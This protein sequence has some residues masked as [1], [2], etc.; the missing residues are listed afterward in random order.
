[1]KMTLKDTIAQSLEILANRD[2]QHCMSSNDE[3]VVFHASEMVGSRLPKKYNHI[4]MNRNA[5]PLCWYSNSK[6]SDC[7]I[8]S[9]FKKAYAKVVEY[10]EWGYDI[11]PGRVN[12]LSDILSYRLQEYPKIKNDYADKKALHLYLRNLNNLRK[13]CKEMTESEIYDFSFDMVYDFFD[14][15]SLSE[16]TLSLSF[17]IM[18]W[19]QRE[20]DLIPVAVVGD[21]DEFLAALNPHSEYMP[22]E[23]ESKKKF[24]H[25]MRKTLHTHLKLFIRNEPTEKPTS[26]DRILKLIK[27]NPKH[28]AKEMASCLGL[29][30]Q[31]VQKQIAI[32]KKEKRLKRT[33]ADHGGKWEVIEKK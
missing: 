19:I 7:G 23:R 14:N 8:N 12:K 26:R 32:L 22:T 11:T 25:F 24:R 9:G 2:F 3:I 21:K 30:V 17:L 33:G 5:V 20:C 4:L 10:L 18:Y 27:D 28:T 16:E 1:M 31:A 13:H 29:S 6:L 15:M